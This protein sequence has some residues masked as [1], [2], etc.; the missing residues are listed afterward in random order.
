MAENT[1]E[2]GVWYAVLGAALA[3]PGAKVNRREFLI[4]EFG[5]YC[6]QGTLERIINEGSV[7][8]GIEVTLMDKIANE[9][10]NI[11][12]GIATSISFATGIPGGLTM[13]ATVPADI[14]QYYYHVIVVAQKLAY[15]Y[16]FADLEI[17]SDNFKSLLT[18][19]IGVMADIED[20]DKTVTEI[21]AAQ[22]SKDMTAI[23]LGKVFNKTIIRIAIALSYRLTGKSLFKSIWKAIPIVGGLVSGGITLFTF[24]PMCNNLK[25][26]LHSS[27]ETITRNLSTKLLR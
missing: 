10:I 3:I 5:K 2:V 7:K 26:R 17:V 23:A 27:T 1:G 18:L 9:T 22:V 24:H 14:A 19:L 20:A 8:A 6:N 16:G 13:L 11:H 12:S 4:K 25:D 21:F 15:I